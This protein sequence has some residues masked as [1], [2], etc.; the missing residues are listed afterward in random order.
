MTHSASGCSQTTMTLTLETRRC[1][2]SA[3]RRPGCV[4][5]LKRLLAVLAAVSPERGPVSML[6]PLQDLADIGQDITL[7][8]MSRPDREF[9]VRK[10]FAD[11]IPVDE[12]DDE[13]GL[14]DVSNLA[15]VISCVRKKE[16]RKRA[17]RPPPLIS[18]YRG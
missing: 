13:S 16:Y 7:W 6:V 18:S 1:G 3:C 8:Y 2:S 4:H 17:V 5:A 11:T 14:K 12:E 9:D 10:F 15:D